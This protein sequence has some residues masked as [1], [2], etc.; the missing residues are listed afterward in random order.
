L[1][2]ISEVKTKTA[3]TCGFWLDS[4]SWTTL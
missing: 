2:H 1:E 3:Q 4:K